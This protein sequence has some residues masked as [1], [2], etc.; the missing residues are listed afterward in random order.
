MTDKPWGHL[1]CPHCG[2][3]FSRGINLRGV[4]NSSIYRECKNCGIMFNGEI[5]QKFYEENPEDFTI[6][7]ETMR[8]QMIPMGDGIEKFNEFVK[9]KDIEKVE[10]IEVPS[11]SSGT[12]C[13][14]V[15]WVEE[16]KPTN[17]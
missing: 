5:A 16:D 11:R 17:V 7:E 6:E 15:F 9:D 3:Q 4:P 8:V 14:V 12:Y 1:R 10:F 2:V 13:A